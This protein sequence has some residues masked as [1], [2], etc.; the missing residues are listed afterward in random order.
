MIQKSDESTPAGFGGRLEGF[1][2]IVPEGLGGTTASWT[3]E[4][5]V[6]EGERVK[7]NNFPTLVSKL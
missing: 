5:A 3:P 1:A 6:E 2:E 7:P 4:I